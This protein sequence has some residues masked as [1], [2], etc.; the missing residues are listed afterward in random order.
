MLFL[1]PTAFFV[2][3][4]SVRPL[5]QG[6]TQPAVATAKP[7]D[8]AL[9]RVGKAAPDFIL[10][11]QLDRNVTLKEA[12][13]AK[14]WV[15]LAFYPADMTAGCTLQNK[16]YSAGKDKFAPLSALVYT[17]STQDTKSK[18]AFCLRDA[19]TNTL[20]SDVGGKVAVAYGVLNKE[21]GV[22]RRVTFYINPQGKVVAVDTKIN[23]KSAAEDT[24][25]MLQ[26]LQEVKP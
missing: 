14:K 9:E 11:D 26:K 13:K 4:I 18:Q 3:E 20:L 8:P 19:L 5:V 24:V 7:A 12:Q 25:A 17:I 16:S 23:V 6:D 2:Q 15:V 10:P 21:R 22:A 1:I